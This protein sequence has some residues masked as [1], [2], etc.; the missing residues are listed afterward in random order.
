VRDG[1]R[2]H[3]IRAETEVTRR[4]LARLAY[5]IVDHAMIGEAA[6][7]MSRE[8]NVRRTT[9]QSDQPSADR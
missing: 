2:A 8:A 1:P 7:R 6:I 9:A 3:A 4:E 5:A